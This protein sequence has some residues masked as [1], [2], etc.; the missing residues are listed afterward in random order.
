MSA[1]SDMRFYET[2]VPPV[3]WGLV[4][5]IVVWGVDQA[6]VDSLLEANFFRFVGL[7]LAVV[8]VVYAAVAVAGFA[9]V[10]TTVNPHAIDR[11]SVLV[12]DG[13]FRY[14]RNPMYLGMLFVI[15]GWGLNRGSLIALIVGAGVFVATMTVAQIKPEER[16]MTELF[17]DDYVQWCRQVRRWM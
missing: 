1:T 9:S 5:A 8:G 2:K 16:K 14:T 7:A 6:G 13:V 17:G 3:V 12:T 4:A 15:V 10:G 11:A